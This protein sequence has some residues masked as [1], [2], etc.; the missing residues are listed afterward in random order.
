MKCRTIGILESINGRFYLTDLN[1]A[2]GQSEPLVQVSVVYLKSS[3]QSTVIPYPVQVFGTLLWKN[4]PVIFAKILQVIT[5]STAIRMKNVLGSITS[6]YLA[7]S[8]PE[9]EEQQDPT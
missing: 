3:P 5:V 9:H 1:E 8:I 2:E 7:K 4:R 6:M